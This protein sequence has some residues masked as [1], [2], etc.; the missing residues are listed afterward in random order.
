MYPFEKYRYYTTGNKI[1]AVSTYA[2]KT[3]RGIAKCADGDEFDLEKGKQLAALRCALRIANKRKERASRKMDEADAAYM[4]AEEYCDKMADYY[5]D[6][7]DEVME[8][9]A[10]IGELLD[11]M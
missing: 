9:R 4:A 1:I 2:G 7:C 11:E 6:A 10:A 5:G 3:V 8:I